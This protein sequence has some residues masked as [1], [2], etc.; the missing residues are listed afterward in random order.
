MIPVDMDIVVLIPNKT[1]ACLG[2]MSRKLT[3][4]PDHAKPPMLIA[5]VMQKIT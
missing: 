4:K 1:L 5:L 3:L 2:A